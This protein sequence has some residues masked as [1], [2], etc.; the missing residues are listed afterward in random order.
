M[1]E[2]VQAVVPLQAGVVVGGDLQVEDGVHSE[3]RGIIE[4]Q[5]SSRHGASAEKEEDVQLLF[6]GKVRCIRCMFTTSR[7]AMFLLVMAVK[8]PRMQNCQEWWRVAASVAPGEQ[9]V[10]TVEMDRP[11]Q[12]EQPQ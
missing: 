6:A 4:T 9:D 10:W 2:E 3:L 12:A 8:V 7:V 5:L 1:V 11:V